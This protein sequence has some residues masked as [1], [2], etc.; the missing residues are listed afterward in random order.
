LKIGEIPPSKGRR[1]SVSLERRAN[2]NLLSCEK[3]PLGEP[4][5]YFE[6]VLS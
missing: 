4:L 1:L 6:I 2:C 3:V 5:K